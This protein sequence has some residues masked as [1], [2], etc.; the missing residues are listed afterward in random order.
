MSNVIV[1]RGEDNHE[2]RFRC[3]WCT[4]DDI[5]TDAS[6]ITSWQNIDVF[7]R[8][9]SRSTGFSW[10]KKPE[11][12]CLSIELSAD[13]HQQI[14]EEDLGCTAAFQFVLDCLSAASHDDDHESV[15]RLVVPRSSGYIVR[16]DIMSLRLLGCSLVK[17]VA[18]F[19]KPQQFFDGKPI[20]VDV[21]PSAFAKSIGGVLLMKRKT[22][23]HANS[24]GKIGNGIVALDSLL[25]SLDHELR[26]RLSFPWLSTQP[27]AER[28]PTLAIVDGG[29]RGPDDGGTGGSIYMAAEALGIDMVVLD[30]PGHWVNGPKY[31]HWRKAFVP[32]ELQLE[33]DAGFS[34]RI[35]DAVRSYE[36]HIDGILTFR[37]HYKVPVAEAA[38]QLSLPTYP[39]SAYVIATDK[40]KTSVSEGH[41]AYQASSAE[42]AVKIV[43]EHHLEFPLIIKPC[44]GFLSEGV[45]RV[46]NLS[47]L[48]AGAQAIDTDRHGKEFVIEKYCEGPEVDANVVLCDGEVIFFEVSDDFPK[49]ADA[50]SHGTV[51]N[52]IELANV[53]PSALPEHEQA[54]LRDSLRQSLVRM[55]FLDGFFHLE[56]RVEN[57]SMEYGTKN[58]VLDLRMRDNVEKGTPAPAAWLIEVNPRPP[59]IQ[60][61]EAAR[62]TYGV[63]YFG[64]G[65]LFALDDK[66]RAKQLS[67]AFAQGPQYWCE[68]V[69]IPVEKGG[70]YESGDVCEELFARRPDLVDHVSGSFCFLKK[71]DHVADPLK[72]GLNSWVAYFNV[73]SRESRE[74][75]LELADCVRR[76]VRFSIV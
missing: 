32:L 22:K 72:T 5:T 35:A 28:R 60:A 4:R 49:G 31:R 17:S 69:F 41:I 1:V 40:F 37:D 64:L 33:P 10:A 39:P 29:L 9:I 13:K 12:A 48:E 57:S 71:G 25:S 21:F 6:G 68:M 63:D 23:Q 58:Q 55:G 73:Y 11:S 43:Q 75:V 8:E 74:H 66:P 51:K 20:N 65:L 50:N 62:H 76:E 38:V 14:H 30:N 45:F 42:Q 59:G 61:S 44:N 16:S 15:A 19:A 47:Q 53:L 18:S 2:A 24:N 67:H 46:E 26:N 54:L 27:P 36:G 7:F 34:N 3:S 70:V 52:F 56:A